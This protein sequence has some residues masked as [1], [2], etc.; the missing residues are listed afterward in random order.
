VINYKIHLQIQEEDIDKKLIMVVMNNFNKNNKKSKSISINNNKIYIDLIN[1]I[2][3][4]NI[5]IKDLEYNIFIKDHNNKL[6]TKEM[7]KCKKNNKC[8]IDIKCKIDNN[9]KKDNKYKIDNNFRKDSRDKKYNKNNN[10][11]KFQYKIF[12]KKNNH[13][14]MS[15]V[16]IVDANSYL[17]NAINARNLSKNKM[18]QNNLNNK[19]QNKSNNRNQSNPNS[20][21]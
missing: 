8:K 9:F 17:N 3:H 4:F 7:K 15:N 21:K 2:K 5:Q 6:Y 16:H 20:K 19:N 18:Y 1:Y 12:S 14:Y 13:N 10:I 11:I